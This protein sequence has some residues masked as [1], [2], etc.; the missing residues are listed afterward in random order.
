MFESGELSDEDVI[1]FF[2]YLINEGHAW[3][4]QGFYG[5][6]A[7]ELIEGGFCTLSH[8]ETFGHPIWGKQRIP[9]KFELKPKSKSPLL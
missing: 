8:K 7:E 9:T 3:N 2:Q 6:T 5:R 4:L 1:K